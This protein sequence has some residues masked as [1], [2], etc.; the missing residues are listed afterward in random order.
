MAQKK[1]VVIGGGTGTFTVLQALRDTPF[2]LTAI[3]STADDGGSTGVLRDELGVLPPGDLRQALVALASDSTMLR[4]LFS[5]RFSEGSLKGHSFG[6]LLISA[7]EKVTGSFDAAIL[8]AGKILSI[9]GVVIPVTTDQ[10]HLRAQGTD[11]KVI[12][13]E[14]AIE[15]HIWAEGP[16]LMRFWVEPPC[17]IHPLAEQAIK[18]ADLIVLGPGSIYTSLI[19]CLLVDGVREALRSTKGKLAFVVNLMTE[20]GQAGEYS[21]QDFVDLIETYLGGPLIDYAL[22]NTKHPTEDLLQKYKQEREKTPV[23]IDR[24]KLKR[25]HYRLFGTNLLANQ[26][27]VKA[28]KNDPLAKTR[29]FIRHDSKRLAKALTGLLYL[30][31][32]ETLIKRSN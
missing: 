24:K 11:G 25:L 31:E 2:H 6:N 23:R 21:A 29:T 8:E 14:H 7:L 17:G 4:E 20:K 19:P 15:E 9:K 1:V 3:V 27:V 5:Y 32:A 22:C 30:G 28:D 16:S 26:P 12:K 10:M 13:G 18:E